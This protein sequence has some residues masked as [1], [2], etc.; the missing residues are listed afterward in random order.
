MAD[1]DAAARA[2][3]IDPQA[4]IDSEIRKLSAVKKHGKRRR[5]VKQWREWSRKIASSHR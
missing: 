4:F 1:A 3:G 5:L 2:G